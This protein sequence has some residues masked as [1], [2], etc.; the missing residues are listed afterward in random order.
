MATRMSII[1]QLKTDLEDKVKSVR[2][3]THDLFEVNLGIY[4]FDYYSAYPAVA[5][6]AYSDEKDE[7]YLDDNRHRLLNFLIYGYH[8]TDGLNDFDKIYELADDI[9][10]FLMS[11]DWTHSNC[12]IIDET[13]ITV[14]GV[15]NQRCMFD[16][17][18]SVQYLQDF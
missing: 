2:G 8:D 4:N 11:T 18:F 9:E 3:Y 16:L 10:K 5:Y 17:R 7:E 14:G 13:V 12:T 15:D 6:W 1:N